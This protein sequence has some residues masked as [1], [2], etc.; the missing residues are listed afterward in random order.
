MACTALHC[1]A[2]LFSADWFSLR[3]LNQGEDDYAV[4]SVGNEKAEQLKLHPS[5]LQ[6]VGTYMNIARAP[7]QPQ[8]AGP[9]AVTE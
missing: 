8:R 7:G 1:T 5:V 4:V 9:L 2:C 6:Y 3:I